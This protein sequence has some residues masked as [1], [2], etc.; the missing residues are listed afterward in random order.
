MRLYWNFL[1]LGLLGGLFFSTLL[2]AHVLRLSNSELV[3]DGPRAA[4]TLQVHLTD[5]ENKFS[6]AD[7]AVLK[8]YLPTRLI[9]SR[10]DQSCRF[11][12]LKVEKDIPQERVTLRLHYQCP[13]SASDLKVGYDLFYGDPAHR[14]LLKVKALGK[15]L[16]FTFSPENT[17]FQVAS[18]RQWNAFLNFL[19]LGLEH[20]LA[21][22]DHILFLIT[23][24]FA[25]C[26]FKDLF[27]LVTAFTVGHSIS[28]ALSVQNI[29]SLPPAIVEPLI[30]ASIVFVAVHDL[31]RKP[32]HTPWAMI[33]LTFGF[34]LIHGLGFS[35]AL[36]E[37]ELS[38]GG[39]ALPLFSFNLGVELGQLLLISLVYPTLLGLK[40]LAKIAYPKVKRVVLIAISAVGL[41]WIAQRVFFN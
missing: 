30:A 20:I 32:D 6:R 39:L 13:A 24:V 35:Y 1:R 33:L 2:H 21:G 34:G 7:E 22:Y 12:D 41:Y 40:R 8:N 10:G 36:R 23:L 37:A 16:S 18:G 5:Y 9:L 4:W 25:A 19:K 15:D 17:E 38:G 31:L 3:L 29:V 28:L 11:E 27:G 14:H 26:R